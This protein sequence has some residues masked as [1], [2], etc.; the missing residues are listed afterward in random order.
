MTK[1]QIIK[2]EAFRLGFSA[3]GIAK[4]E[5]VPQD[6][7][8]KFRS[9][10][11]SGRYGNMDYLK[12]NDHLRFDP[13]EL[14]PGC[15]SIICLAINYYPRVKQPAHAPQ[16]AYYAYGKDYHKVVKKR[17]DKLLQFIKDHIDAQVM[18]RSY[19]DSAPV[20][21]RY[22]AVKAGIGFRGKSGLLI[23]P[24][25]G[26]F[27][28]LGELFLTTEL[29]PD[30]PCRFSCGGCT[31]CIDNCPAKA[32]TEGMG[33]N[34][35]KCLSYLTI[36]QEDELTHEQSLIL[37]NRLYGCDTCQMVCPHNKFAKATEET[38]FDPNE[39][40][41]DLTFD[42]LSQMDEKQ[43]LKIFAGT[44]V[45]RA[46]YKGIMRTARALLRRREDHND[47]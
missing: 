7:R 29:V 26:T 17:S 8:D 18:G 27:F 32:I 42:S 45:K 24:R 20:L 31:K 9:E 21:E 47:K 37:G 35:G 30:E 6:V 11:M 4:A 12:R 5:A 19:A 14:F 13:K 34:A 28:V 38:A 40:L 1:E 39:G 15:R 22:W 16:V 2:E 36:E 33:F 41:F 43:Y 3:V 23:I 25:K 46:G 10:V 44:S